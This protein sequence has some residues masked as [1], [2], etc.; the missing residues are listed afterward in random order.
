MLNNINLK[1]IAQLMRCQW[2]GK[3]IDYGDD[4]QRVYMSCTD[5]LYYRAA[6][7]SDV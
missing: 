2:C 1:I 3:E 5:C 4:V 6:L 7:A